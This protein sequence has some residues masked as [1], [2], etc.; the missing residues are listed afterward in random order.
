MKVPCRWMRD[1]VDM[2]VDGN[3]VT[4]LAERLT[5]A[6]LEVEEITESGPLHGVVV[7]RVTACE[8]HPDSDHLSLCTV[9]IGEASLDLVC[10]ADNVR[11][12]ILVPVARIGAVLPSGMK[13]KARTVRGATSHGMICSRA[14]LGLEDRSDGIWVLEPSLGLSVGDRLDQHLEF[15]DFILDIKVFSNR[16]D[17]ASVYGVARE[18]AAVMDRPLRPLNV[19][20][21]ES[22]ERAADRIRVAIENPDDTPRYAARW[23]EGVQIGPSPLRVQHRLIKAGMRPRSNIVDATNYAM[24]ETGQPY[25]PFDADLIQGTV[26][27]RRAREGES[28]RTLDG[29]DRTLDSRVLVIT[30]DDA[31]IALAGVMGG[32]SSEIRPESRRVLLEI[33]VFNNATIRRS[34]RAVGLRSEASQRFER[35]LSPETIPWVADRAAHL[36]QKL[37]G[38]R[39]LAGMADAYPARPHPRTLRL[40]PTRASQLLGLDLDADTVI[41]L[42]RRL[43]IPAQK[44]DGAVS[45]DVPAFRGD[46]QREADL[47]E[48]VGRIYGYDRLLASPPHI[49]LRVGRKDAVERAKDR[50]RA[51]LTGLGMDETISDGFDKREW[52]EALEIDEDDLVVTRNPM[53][54]TQAALRGSLL[55]GVLA[56]VE[57]NLRRGVDGGMLFEL[58]RTFSRQHGERESLAGALFGRTGLPL[59]GKQRFDLASAK[60]AIE[61]MF[62]S[63]NVTN[64]EIARSLDRPYL[65]PGRSAQFTQQGVAIGF[66]GELSPRLLERFAVPTEIILFEIDPARL[67]TS[68]EQVPRYEPVPVLPAA[69]RDLSLSAPRSLEEAQI[70]AVLASEPAIDSILLYDVFEGEQVGRGR[71]SLTYEVALRARDHTLTDDEVAAIVDRLAA[72]LAEHDVR[73]RTA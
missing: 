44:A 59:S 38:G 11:C 21:E 4:R 40:R 18:I 17:C 30:D 42:L 71:K 53:A 56:V 37:S 12:D 60:G 36:I 62:R 57:T 70:R 1:Y 27:I 33:A 5:L 63:L 68:F 35:G 22:P 13:I 24:L 32:E 66:L 6:G 55:P 25:H 29:V 54:A 19:S 28:F 45:V 23:I 64:V 2:D 41:D 46:L 72:Q 51:V 34:S 69:K 31:P 8:P 9:D 16:P 10:G 58:G 39:V 52:R 49:S 26:G 14:E 7:G 43:Q 20:L 3:A 15:D 48:E 50:L 61:A 73:L 67:L 65:H 47:I